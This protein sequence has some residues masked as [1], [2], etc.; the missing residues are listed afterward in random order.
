[1][2]IYMYNS[3]LDSNIPVLW[4]VNILAHVQVIAGFIIPS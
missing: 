1:M 4:T 2:I 3:I